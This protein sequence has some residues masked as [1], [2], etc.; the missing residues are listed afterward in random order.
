[1]IIGEEYSLGAQKYLD[2][3]SRSYDETINTYLDILREIRI[4]S[5]IEGDLANAIDEFIAG[6][7]KLNGIMSNM[8]EMINEY[9][10]GFLTRIEEI[11][12]YKF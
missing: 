4:S 9:I 7:D 1:M 3:Q 5:I 10:H 12:S 8:A 6:A 11:D 2:R